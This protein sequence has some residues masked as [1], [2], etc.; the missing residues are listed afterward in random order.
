MKVTKVICVVASLVIAILFCFGNAMAAEKGPIHFVML[1]DLTGPAHAQ[2]APEGWACEDYIK[3]LNK[4]GG[5]NGHPLTVEII[6]TKYQLPLIRTAYARNKGRKYVTISFDAIS[7]GI[8]AMKEQFIKDKIPVSMYTGHGPALYP[9]GWVMAAMPPYDDTLCA[10]ADWVKK[11]WRENR[12]P[13]MALLLGDYAAGRSPEAAKWYLEKIGIDVVSIEY[14]PILPTDTSDILI[15]MRDK[16]PD[17]V[18]DTLMPDQCKVVLKDRLK[19]GIKIPQANFVFNSDLIKQTVPLEAYRGYMGLQCAHSWW[20][21]DVPGVKLAYELYKHRGPI[22]N[23]TYVLALAG[24]MA[25]VEAVKNA[26]NAVGY[27]NLDGQAIYDGYMKV[28]NFTA[29]GLANEISYYP[30]DTR[31]SKWIKICK[32]NDDGS[33]SNITDWFEAPHNLKLKAKEG[34]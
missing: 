8:E 24:I 25:W 2:V 22:P 6:D 16:K 17:Y 9:A 15:R 23:S 27:E 33:I 21:K 12:K 29:M 18:F 31:G 7:G 4:N 30:D 19:L 13:R 5:I 26:I 28:K 11:N 1:T 10:F 20:E 14:V 3:W 34:K 32:F